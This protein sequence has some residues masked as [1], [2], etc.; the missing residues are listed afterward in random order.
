M[1]IHISIRYTIYAFSLIWMISC[2]SASIEDMPSVTDTRVLVSQAF[3][4]IDL[5]V[6]T[7][8]FNMA[9][10]ERIKAEMT[11]EKDPAKQ[12]N[13]GISYAIELLKAGKTD[14]AIQYFNVMAQYMID[15]NIVTE[16]KTR[17]D[18]YSIM[19]I[20]YM[21]HGE[22]ENCLKNHNHQSCYLPI[23]GDG[24]HELTFG[25]ENAISLYETLLKEFPED[26][27]SKYLLNIAYMTLGKYP[28]GV[29]A[30]W[31]I[32]PSWFQNKKKIQPFKDIAPE[33]GLNR[34]NLAGGTVIDDFTNDGWLDI[35]ISSWSPTEELIFYVN[36][37]D[38]SF[39]DQTKAYKLDGQVGILNLNQTDYNN[40]GW[41]DIFLMR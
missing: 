5:G 37:G 6:V 34:Q 11:I 19:A 18:L 4:S 8:N 40:D 3:D 20:T 35:I 38:G 28:D 17:R 14:E 39:T 27:E 25:S 9:R 16:P 7:S 36:N 13:L 21:R 31:R 23:A 26:L 41:L 32:D 24:V 30:A 22:I 29:P 33:L 12:L 1:S 10:A 2:K 15:N